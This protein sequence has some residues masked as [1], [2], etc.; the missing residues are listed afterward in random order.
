MLVLGFWECNWMITQFNNKCWFYPL[1]WLQQLLI[2][3]TN[4]HTGRFWIERAIIEFTQWKCSSYKATKIC[5]K[6]AV[7][8]LSSDSQK[9]QAIQKK[10][11]LKCGCLCC[12][13]SFSYT[14][15]SQQS[16]ST[17]YRIIAQNVPGIS[18]IHWLMWC[19]IHHSSLHPIQSSYFSL[20]TTK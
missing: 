9:E 8:H 20:G 14:G 2:A 13:A 15:Q 4:L 17:S 5:R 7:K 10:L 3:Q 16:S 12:P 6:K 19:M 18:A 11:S 1:S